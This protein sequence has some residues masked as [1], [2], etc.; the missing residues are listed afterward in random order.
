MQ[1]Y[2]DVVKEIE[3]LKKKEESEENQLLIQS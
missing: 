1:F 2:E 3:D